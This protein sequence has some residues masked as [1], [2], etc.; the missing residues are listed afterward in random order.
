[1]KDSVQGQV[2]TEIED[3]D[4]RD[5]KSIRRVAILRLCKFRHNSNFF[6]HHDI[7]HFNDPN[8]IQIPAQ[9]VA[10]RVTNQWTRSSI[11]LSRRPQSICKG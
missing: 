7:H 3:G 5:G 10:S 8:P 1:M 11:I 9:A 6:V 4:Q 2:S